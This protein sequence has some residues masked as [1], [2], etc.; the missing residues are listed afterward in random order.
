MIKFSELKNVIARIVSSH[1]FHSLYIK[2]GLFSLADK[3][4]N[5]NIMLDVYKNELAL[6]LKIYEASYDP[7]ETEYINLLIGL[8]S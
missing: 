6:R 3:K 4:R 1:F 7:F 2:N 8:L 5:S